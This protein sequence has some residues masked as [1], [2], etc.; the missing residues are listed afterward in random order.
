MRHSCRSLVV[1]VGQELADL[2]STDY[3]TGTSAFAAELPFPVTENIADAV[4]L[5]GDCRPIPVIH[6]SP[7]NGNYAAEIGPSRVTP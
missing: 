7:L 1:R 2:G 5:I 6:A 3:L 4:S